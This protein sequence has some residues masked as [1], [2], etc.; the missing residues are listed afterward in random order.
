MYTCFREA[1]DTTIRKERTMTTD[2]SDEKRRTINLS[3][4]IIGDMF[5]AANSLEDLQEAYVRAY[6]Y[7]DMLGEG[8]EDLRTWVPIMHDRYRLQMQ[9]KAQQIV[10]DAIDEAR[11]LTNASNEDLYFLRRSARETFR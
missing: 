8:Y 9:A 7:L 3:C 5:R 1:K 4:D 6:D 11:K 10:L 2:T